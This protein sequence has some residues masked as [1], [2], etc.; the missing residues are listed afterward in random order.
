V[1]AY[2]SN[3]TGRFE[4][5]VRP[6]SGP[7][8][9]V[10]ISIAGGSDPAWNPK[11]GEL[12]FLEPAPDAAGQFRMMAVAM[13]GQRPGT[14]QPLFAFRATDLYA[15][16]TPTNCYDVMPDGQHFVVTKVLPRDPPPPVTHINLVQNWVEELKAKVPVK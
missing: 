2:A 5:Y 6:R 12:F 13:A 10:Q 16:C 4:V 1:I 11:G 9:S 15:Q 7:G 14:P 8:P 3:K